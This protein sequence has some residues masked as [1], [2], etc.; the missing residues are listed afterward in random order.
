MNL[1][2][3]AKNYPAQYP[4]QARIFIEQ[5][6]QFNNPL[7]FFEVNTANVT[8]QFPQNYPSFD[9][10]LLAKRRDSDIET[11]DY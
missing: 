11:F 1:V 3:F 7:A 10:T 4:N 2:F 9:Q 5:T 6:M 8:D